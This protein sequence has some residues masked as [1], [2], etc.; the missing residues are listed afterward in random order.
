MSHCSIET[1]DGYRHAEDERASN[2]LHNLTSSTAATT[3]L[4]DER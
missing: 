4:A 1:T 2:P 3:L